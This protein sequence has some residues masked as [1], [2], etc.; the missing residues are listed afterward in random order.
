MT[1]RS[2]AQGTHKRKVRV[3]QPLEV[4]G[5]AAIASHLVGDGRF[6]PV[7]IVDTAT[8]PELDELVRVHQYLNSGDCQCQW[9][10]NLIDKNQ[11]ILHLE[12]IR[13]IKAAVTIGLDIPSQG[14]LVDGILMAQ[15]LYLLPGRPGDRFIEKQESPKIL[16]E[17]PRGDFGDA[18]EK[19]VRHVLR[20]VFRNRGL[21]RPEARVA[22]EEMISKTR[23]I[24]TLRFKEPPK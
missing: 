1:K 2:K 8:R 24:T 10:T 3:P 22:T 11:V 4:V 12:F 16:V 5:D 23:E 20:R 6:I 18:W 21:S 9:G 14:I 15:A 7:L 13:P 17:V 19:L